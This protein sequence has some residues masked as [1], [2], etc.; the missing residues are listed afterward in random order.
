MLLRDLVA[1]IATFPRTEPAHKLDIHSITDDSRTVTPGC[2]FIAR[3]GTKSDGRVFIADAIARGA[4]AVLYDDSDGSGDP[5]PPESTV[6]RVK[7][8]AQKSGGSGAASPVSAAFPVVEP[9]LVLAFTASNSSRATRL[10]VANADSYVPFRS[11]RVRLC[12]PRY[13]RS[14]TRPARNVP[15]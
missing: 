2:L 9:P 4:A 13:I 3:R 12:P 1:G 15:A 10:P 5:C 6:V 7:L 8:N 14:I 11:S